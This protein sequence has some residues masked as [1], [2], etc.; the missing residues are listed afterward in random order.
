MGRRSLGGGE[1]FV[2]GG[3][4]LAEANIF[5]NRAREQN[6]LLQHDAD[7]AA[8][9]AK[10]YIAH[11]NAIQKHASLCSLVQPRNQVD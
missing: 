8:Q 6:R 10:L 5:T 2:F 7:M 11:I 9:A 4:W 1:H 3:L